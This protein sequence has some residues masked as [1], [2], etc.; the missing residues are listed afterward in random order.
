MAGTGNLLLKRGSVMPY[1]Y[2]QDDTVSDTGTKVLLNGMPAAQIVGLS[3]FFR[4]DTGIA[5]F[6]KNNYPNRLWLGMDNFGSTNGG[7]AESDTTFDNTFYSG[8]YPYTPTP[9]TNVDQTRPLWVGAEI[10]GYYPL[11]EDGGSNG[12]YVILKADWNKPSDYVLVTQKAISAMPLR[13]Y[14]NKLNLSDTS[15]PDGAGDKREFIEFS[16]WTNT[17]TTSSGNSAA[18]FNSSFANRVSTTLKYCFPDL[19]GNDNGSWIPGNS[20]T[21]SPHYFLCSREVFAANGTEPATVQLGFVESFAAFNAYLG[22]AAGQKVALLGEDGAT[23]GP[24]TFQSPIGIENYLDLRSY[25]D[26]SNPTNPATIKSSTATAASIFDTGVLDISMGGAAEL[27][28]I[29]DASTDGATVTTI[30]G[31]L[32]VTGT[33]TVGDIDIDGGFY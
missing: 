28:E 4:S 3:E 13:V 29:G 32:T 33:A 14:E 31:D 11:K 2:T 5:G 9:A 6:A 21:G 15:P 16:A 8:V 17:G 19:S 20:Y 12:D 26:I 18:T 10:R 24:Q 25:T 30:Y 27:I 7:T 23:K 22:D 1:D